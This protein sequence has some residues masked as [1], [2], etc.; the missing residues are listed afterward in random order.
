MF[1]SSPFFIT[2]DCFFLGTY[3]RAHAISLLVCMT[4]FPNS[5]VYGVKSVFF[6]NLK[7]RLFGRQRHD[8]GRAE[9]LVTGGSVGV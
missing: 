8:D 2:R 5:F 9:K 7:A 4:N 6:Y 1:I 3:S